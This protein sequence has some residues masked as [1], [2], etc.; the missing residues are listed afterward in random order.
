MPHEL[1]E[2]IGSMQSEIQF[3]A[4][5]DELVTAGV[6]RGQISILARE[7]L[8][9]SCARA[10]G[11][12]ISSLPHTEIALWDDRQQLRTLLTSLAATTASVAAAGVVLAATGGTAAPAVLAAAAAGGGAGGLSAL[13][14]KRYTARTHEWAK[15]QL[16]DGGILIAVH[17]NSE[18]QRDVAFAILRRYCGEEVVSEN[19]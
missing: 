12:D 6:D 1:E 7:E 4:A 13:L 17:A 15:R 16:L 2:V 8:V 18:A 14:G 3:E 19:S 5:I 10:I 9:K 11:C